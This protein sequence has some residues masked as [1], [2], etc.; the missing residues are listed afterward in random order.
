MK[1]INYSFIIPHKNSYELLNRCLKSI[2]QR[3]DV[4][5]IVVDDNSSCI[6][7]L[8]TLVTQYPT[9]ELYLTTK[10]KGAGYARNVGLTKA[11]G[12]WLVFADADDFFNDGFDAT[13]NKYINAEYDIIFFNS[14]SKFSENLQ[15]TETRNLYIKNGIKNKDI[16]MLKYGSTVV[17]A[18]FYKTDLIKQYNIRFDE[19]IA[20]NDVMFATKTSYHAQ[21]VYIDDSC[22]YCSTVN[23]SSLSYKFT[24]PNLDSRFYVGLSRNS[25]LEKIGVTQYRTNILSNTIYYRLFGTKAFIRAMLR[26][27]KLIPLKW[28]IKDLQRSIRQ[29]IKHGNKRRSL[30]NRNN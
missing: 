9:V 17:W 12:K 5:V 23:L 18:K 21:K 4:Q 24:I 7:E 26:Y 25:F 14:N 11:K 2:P 27:V 16:G 3:N 6:D 22:I 10:D 20:S 8:Q 28:Q 1:T 13:L 19:T 29:Y 15:E 30:I